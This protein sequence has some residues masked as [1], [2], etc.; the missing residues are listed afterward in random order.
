MA[1]M[2]WRENVVSCLCER[3][4]DVAELIRCFR[5]AVNKKDC[6]LRL[7][8]EG[9]AFCVKYP[10]LRVG[11]PNPGLTVLSFGNGFGC[12]CRVV[13]WSLNC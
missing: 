3:N 11:L 2:I 7:V 13:R 1:A 5:E 8:G 6:T 9:A 10:D 4:N 12:Y